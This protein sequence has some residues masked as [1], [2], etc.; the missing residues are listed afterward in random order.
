ME[1]LSAIHPPV[2]PLLLQ[3]YRDT[4]R[5]LGYTLAVVSL[6]L[7]M[8][9]GKARLPPRHKSEWCLKSVSRMLQE[10]HLVQDQ[11]PSL[12]SLVASVDVDE[13]MLNV[14]R[15]HLTY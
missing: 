2:A 1:R 10:L 8:R 7:S 11:S 12:I 15:C 13:L 4:A 5:S 3:A 6:P 14:L 9:D